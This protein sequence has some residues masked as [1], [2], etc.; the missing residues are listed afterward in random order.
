MMYLCT[1]IFLSFCSLQSS[2]C[3]TPI[4]NYDGLQ[5]LAKQSAQSIS[6]FLTDSK[7][8]SCSLRLSNHPAQVLLKSALAEQ[9]SIQF[10]TEEIKNNKVEI[11]IADFA[12]RYFRYSDS[13]D[14]VVREFVIRTNGILSTKELLKSIPEFTAN[15]RDTIARKDIV[16]VE[17]PEYIYTKAIIPTEEKSLLSEIAE[18]IV[19]FTVAAISVLLLF[20][21]RS[22]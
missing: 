9:T 10:Y 18:P 5:G 8:D 22:Q 19:L 17:S 11:E 7:I 16:R 4:N 15:V 21:I 2:I 3:N 13:Q 14:S 1:I 6:K 12:V 20:T